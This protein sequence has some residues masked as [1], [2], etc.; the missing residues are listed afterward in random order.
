MQ[1][2]VDKSRLSTGVV[3]LHKLNLKQRKPRWILIV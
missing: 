2:M 1:R 3:E